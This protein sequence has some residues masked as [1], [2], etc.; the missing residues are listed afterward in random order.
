MG[1]NFGTGY[2][3]QSKGILILYKYYPNNAKKNQ[4][5]RNVIYNCSDGKSES[6]HCFTVQTGNISV[7]AQNMVY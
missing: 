4:T 1:S 2:N 6:M 5:K 7:G 3:E